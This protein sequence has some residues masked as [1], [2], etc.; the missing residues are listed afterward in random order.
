M[1]L[2]IS[3]KKRSKNRFVSFLLTLVLIGIG[4]EVQVLVA[5]SAIAAPPTITT[6]VLNASGCGT[7][8]GAASSG[9]T[10]WFYSYDNVSF[11]QIPGQTGRTLGYYLAPPWYEAGF[12]PWIKVSN[13][14][15]EYSS[16]AQIVLNGEANHCT[17]PFKSFTPV[18]ATTTAPSGSTAV[19]ST[20]T[21]TVSFVAAPVSTTL[22]YSWQS[23][24]SATDLS[25][26]STISSAT[27]A[28][29]TLTSDEA[30]KFIR[31]IVVGS[32]TVNGVTE[33][34]TGTSSLTSVIDA[35]PDTTAPTISS[36]N[37]TKTDGS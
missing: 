9:T 15:G 8:T 30:G 23:C 20:L 10:A 19:S 26:C 34:A 12:H 27:N 14:A 16:S 31:S 4:I 6:G 3:R 7:M 25:T 13:S 1:I 29:Y 35:T 11:I 32:S 21:S 5:D 33:S 28:T 37:S 17:A 18:V 22:T 36:I 2:G 24:T